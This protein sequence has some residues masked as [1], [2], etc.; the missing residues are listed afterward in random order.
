MPIVALALAIKHSG[1]LA[2][3]SR[4]IRN[5]IGKIEHQLLPQDDGICTPEDVCREMWH[6]DKRHFLEATKYTSLSIFARH[7]E[8]EDMDLKRLA[9]ASRRRL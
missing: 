1:R 6:R 2:M 8:A 4:A 5:R 9:N 7:F 3:N